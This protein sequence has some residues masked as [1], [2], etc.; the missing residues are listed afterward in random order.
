MKSDNPRVSFAVQCADTF[1]LTGS[2][3]DPLEGMPT[4]RFS[5]TSL[6]ALHAVEDTS[7]RIEDL[8][9]RL[10]CLG[11]FDRSDGPRAA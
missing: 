11:H 2:E 9:T 1:R 3:P 5:E 7:R 10:G 6:R 4:H 8:A